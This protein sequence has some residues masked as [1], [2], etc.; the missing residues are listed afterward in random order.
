[1]Q[2]SGGGQRARKKAAAKALPADDSGTAAA[3][4]GKKAEEDF[5]TELANLTAGD[6]DEECNL[7]DLEMA[8]GAHGSDTQEKP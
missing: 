5:T 3:T 2:A 6:H 7:S 4:D 1:M 8:V